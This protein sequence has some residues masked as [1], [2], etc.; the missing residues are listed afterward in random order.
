VLLLVN[1]RWAEAAVL[2]VAVVIIYVGVGEL[3]GLTSRPRPPDPLTGTSGSGF[4]SGHAVHSI[5]YPWL[6]VTLAIRLRPGM[7]GGTALLVTGFAIAA[8]VGLSRVYLR[9]HYLSDVTSGW[10]LGAA[11]FCACACVAMVVTHL[12]NNAERDV[13]PGARD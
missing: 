9:V 2:L 12:R 7:V 6:A 10:A 11:G 8:L 5:L 13:V 4:P 1:R 3:K